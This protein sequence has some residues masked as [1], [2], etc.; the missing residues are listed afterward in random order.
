MHHFPSKMVF[1][2]GA[3]GLQSPLLSPWRIRP[4]R[5]DCDRRAHRY[6][7]VISG[8]LT[9]AWDTGMQLL[10]LTTVDFLLVEPG[11]SLLE[12]TAV[13]GVSGANSHALGM[14]LDKETSSSSLSELED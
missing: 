1:V 8:K 13:C 6:L 5:R 14:E 3:W 11:S 10:Y 7:Q 9:M 4:A 2:N 12:S